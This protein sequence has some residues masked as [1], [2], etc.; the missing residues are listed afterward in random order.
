[1]AKIFHFGCIWVRDSSENRPEALGRAL[2]RIARPCGV[3]T[4]DSVSDSLP[5]PQ[6]HLQK[7]KR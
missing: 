1:M 5:M 3:G 7:E 4:K 6:G 2:Q